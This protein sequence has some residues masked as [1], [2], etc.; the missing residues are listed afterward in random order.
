[1]SATTLPGGLQLEVDSAKAHYGRAEQLLMRALE[2]DPAL[3]EA[4]VRLARVRAARGQ[5]QEASIE[6]RNVTVDA[7]DSV[8]KYYA[9]M[10]LGNVETTLKTRY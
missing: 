3:T 1:V 4:K 9:L 5:H 2:V 10:F 8:V 7:D 6:L